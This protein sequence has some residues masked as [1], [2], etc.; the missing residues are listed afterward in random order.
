MDLST[1][2]QN[3][4]AIIINRSFGSNGLVIKN[5]SNRRKIILMKNVQHRSLIQKKLLVILE[6]SEVPIQQ[7]PQ[8]QKKKQL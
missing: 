2:Q 6:G 3:P 7:Y 5:A 8:Q 1:A 4:I